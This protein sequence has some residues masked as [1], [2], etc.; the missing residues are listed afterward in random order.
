M[1]NNE[2]TQMT[3]TITHSPELVKLQTELDE[4]RQR[5]YRDSAEVKFGS[6]EAARVNGYYAGKTYGLEIAIDLLLKREEAAR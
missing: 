1:D 6:I 2:G 5:W 4:T 3:T